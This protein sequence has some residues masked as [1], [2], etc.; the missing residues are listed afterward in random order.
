MKIN[1]ING[2]FVANGAIWNKNGD[3]PE[4]YVGDTD[5]LENGELRK[6][7]AE[8]RKANDWEGDVVRRYRHPSIPGTNVCAHCGLTLHDHGWLDKEDQVVCPG[9]LVVT[10]FDKDYNPHYST[11]KPKVF[12]TLAPTDLA[13]LMHKP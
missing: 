3:H 2:E 10:T 8:H 11:I 5:G 1:L 6:F 13:A 9:D 12:N 7:S 4:D